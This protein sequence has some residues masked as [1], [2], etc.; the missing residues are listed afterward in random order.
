ME[1]VGANDAVD[2]IAI[3]L[4][5]VRR[6]AGPEPGDF[7]QHLGAVVDQVRE[8]PGDLVVLPDV[9]GD[10]D[11]DVMCAVAGIGVPPAGSRIQM[12]LRDF[13]HARRCRIATGTSHLRSRR[14]W[15]RGARSGAR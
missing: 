14:A 15:P 12:Q 11:T 9:V 5:V 4:L 10:G 7:G 3:V 8:V 6:S 2:V 1:L 13:P